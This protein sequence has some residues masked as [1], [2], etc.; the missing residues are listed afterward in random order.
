MQI[1]FVCACSWSRSSLWIKVA[2]WYELYKLGFA[3]SYSEVK[4]FKQACVINQ[5]IDEQIQR[6]SSDTSFSQ[7]ITDNVDHTIVTLD[8]NGSFH[9]MGT[10]A[11]NVSSRNHIIEEIKITRPQK[12]LKADIISVPITECN[13]SGQRIF[14]SIHLN[15]SNGFCSCMCCQKHWTLTLSGMQHLFFSKPEIPRPNWSGYRQRI[16]HGDH[17]P[18]A[19][20]TLLP[21]IDLKPI[22][23]PCIYSTLL[24]VINQRK[25]PY[26]TTTWITFN[27]PLWLKATEIAIKKSLDIVIHLEDS[28]H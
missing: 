6:L 7:F 10:I 8:R 4:W 3:A 19:A 28:T 12:L 18:S 5:S 11:S 16:S 27:Q 13:F 17:L 14:E 22:D 20:I 26:I 21:I 1:P 15:T 2:Q 9:E 24:F 25:K 23:Y